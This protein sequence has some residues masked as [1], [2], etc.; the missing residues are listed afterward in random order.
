MASAPPVS[1]PMKVSRS[2]RPENPSPSQLRS[3]LI[4]ALL[5]WAILYP[6]A[7]G[8]VGKGIRGLRAD[9]LDEGRPACVHN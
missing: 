6:S 7:H 2:D 9:R 3:S 5:Q 4:G 1:T 8:T